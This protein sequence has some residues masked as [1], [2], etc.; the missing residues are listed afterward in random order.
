M[1]QFGQALH[2]NP[3]CTIA[4][5]NLGARHFNEDRI[6]QAFAFYRRALA[7]DP[8]CALVHKIIA[9][10]HALRGEPGQAAHH[11]RRSLELDPGQPESAQMRDELALLEATAPAAVPDDG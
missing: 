8:D 6:D 10:I 11:L 1:D 9:T 5:A 3:Y 2:V 4:L 7:I